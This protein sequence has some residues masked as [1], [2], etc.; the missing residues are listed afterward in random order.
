MALF[1]RALALGLAVAVALAPAVASAFAAPHSHS[2]ALATSSHAHGADQAASEDSAGASEHCQSDSKGCCDDQTGSCADACLYKCFGQLA[3]LSSD[4]SPH[5]PTSVH[6][7]G[8]DARRMTDWLN[9]PRPP[10]PRV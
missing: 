6:V 8:P 9:G 5:A 10:P 3:A 1:R 7:D 2:T 4:G